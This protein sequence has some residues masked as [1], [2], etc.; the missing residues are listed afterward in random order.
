MN[1]SE[2]N[3]LILD[4]QKWSLNVAENELQSVGINYKIASLVNKNADSEPM[5][6]SQNALTTKAPLA[7]RA[8]IT[9]QLDVFWS[10]EPANCEKEATRRAKAVTSW[11]WVR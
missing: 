2:P 8:F 7:F 6:N 1:T 9:H 4:L 11:T 3:Q 10:S 5:Y